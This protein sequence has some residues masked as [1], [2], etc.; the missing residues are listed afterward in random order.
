MLDNALF[1]LLNTV[2]TAGL[3]QLQLA[4][5]V[6]IRQNYLPTQIGTP[7]GPTLF[8]YK[9]GDYRR[10][11]PQMAS[12]WSSGAA[13][14]TG[15]VAGNVLTVTGFASGMIEV[16]QALVGA[17][18]PTGVVVQALGTGTG[19]TGK[20]TLNQS[21]TVGS[22]S[23]TT[24][25]AETRTELQQYESTFQISALSTQDPSNPNQLTASDIANYAAWIMQSQATVAALEAQG[26]GVLK[27][28]AVRNVPFSDD[29]QR[30]EFSPSFDFVLTHK[31]I[32]VSSP[33]I[34]SG[35][36]LDIYSV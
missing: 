29:R 33:A 26:V 12:Q 4:S 10:G 1:A 24:V 5:T 36:N 20:Y 19:G 27:I 6:G 7:S 17:G 2:L 3:T 23:M 25:A 34:L 28:G 9:V 35:E 18:I 11:T 31:Q 14:F 21:L 16:G 8:V 30:Y 15:S 22:E 32:I 13:S